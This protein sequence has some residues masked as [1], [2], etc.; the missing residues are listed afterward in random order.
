MASA[1]DEAT[2][3]EK[4]EDLMEWVETTGKSVEEAK[5][6]ALD[7]LGVAA[8]EAEFEILETPRPGLFGRL[9]GE[10]RVRSRVRPAD[11]RPKRDRRRRGESDAAGA[12]AADGP[13]EQS[14][15]EPTPAP[16]RRSRASRSTA[17]AGQDSS[18][19]RRASDETA[20]SKAR[21]D[22][23]SDGAEVDRPEVDPDA[24]GAAALGFVS[25]LV[26]AMGVTATTKL[27]REDTEL[28]VVV[29]GEGLGFLIGPG[30]QTLLA[31]QN[32]ARV[33]AQR[34]LGD[35]D[36]RLRV[37]VSGYRAK[38][39]AALEQFANAVA[40]QVVETGVARS[41]EPMPSADRKVVHDTLLAVPGVESRSVGEDPSRRVVVSPV[42]T[43][44]GVGGGDEST[45]AD[46][47]ADAAGA[48]DVS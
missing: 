4:G 46:G 26:E 2:S 7:E 29:E 47:A 15:G 20:G 21:S 45:Q 5:E 30:G 39:K 43:D 36:T 6:L 28:D 25:G 27:H 16:P 34:R 17:G 10:A 33:A 12:P 23:G 19:R 14:A 44:A 3:N 31:I 38:R 8:D 40:A 9:R 42:T 35:H 24:V 32:L 41:L 18:S 11:V 13:R 22:R 37:D 1:D 48:A